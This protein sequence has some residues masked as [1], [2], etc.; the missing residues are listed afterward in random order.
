MN[1]GKITQ[2]EAKLPINHL[3]NAEKM[4]ALTSTYKRHTINRFIRPE[5]QS[6]RASDRNRGNLSHNV[7]DYFFVYCRQVIPRIEQSI[8]L[9]LLEK[10]T[11]QITNPEERQEVVG[12]YL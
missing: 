9:Q 11:Q 7:V 10:F 4:R 3:F 12:A 6:M 2:R 8:E 1:F 5:N